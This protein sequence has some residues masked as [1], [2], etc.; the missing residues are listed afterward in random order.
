V[1]ERK[2]SFAPRTLDGFACSTGVDLSQNGIPSY[3]GIN[4]VLPLSLE[5][6]VWAINSLNVY[7]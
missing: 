4:S 6:R 2:F 7:Y 1:N 3:L 5:T